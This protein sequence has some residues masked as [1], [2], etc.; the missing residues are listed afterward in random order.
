MRKL[1]L[2]ASTNPFLSRSLPRFRFVR[3]AVRRFVPGE[4][5]ED[6]LGVVPR[7]EDQDIGAVLTLLGENVTRE[8][9]AEA[10]ADHYLEVLRESARRELDAEVSVKL[11]QLGLDLGGGL[12]MDH[13]R[14]LAQA[15][16]EADRFL[17]I[18][19]ES[20]P[21]VDRT[22]DLYEALRQEHEST[23]VC[24]Q[25]YLYR[26]PDDLERLLPLNPAIR[27]VKGAY[28]E[29]PEVAFPR[30]A[31]V[32]AAYM[33]LARR[34]LRARADGGKIRIAI[35]T[36]DTDLV[37]RVDRAA[38]ELGL[39]REDFEVQMLYGIR[40]AAQERLAREG[41][42]LRV[43]ISYGPAWFPWYMRRLAER[44][45]NLWFVLKSLFRPG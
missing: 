30:K 4:E 20:S 16:A 22:L 19:V 45:A 23:G 37:G 11:T 25:A 31:D 13:C 42:R 39:G 10:V 43:L 36:H 27:L 2:W 38:A 33:D 18:D 17:W 12:A 8:D 6:A 15:A 32:D 21:Y 34:L 5:L 40:T 26:T 9:E 35:A 29:S 28:A 14:T 24:I 44:P 7:L 3:R 1:L 41:F